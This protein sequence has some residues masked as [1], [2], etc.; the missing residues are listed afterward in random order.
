MEKEEKIRT[1][2]AILSATNPLP[3]LWHFEKDNSLIVKV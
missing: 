2:K 1:E 3:I